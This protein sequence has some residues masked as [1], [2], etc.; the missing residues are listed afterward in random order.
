MPVKYFLAA[1]EVLK[2]FQ[3][4]FGSFFGS[5][6]AFFK[7]FFVSIWKFFGGSFVLQTCR[8]KRRFRPTCSVHTSCY[9]T[10][11]VNA[12]RF[13]A[14]AG[15]SERTAE[16]QR[17]QKKR[18]WN[19]RATRETL[20]AYT[21]TATPECTK[22]AHRRSLAILTADKSIAGNSATRVIFTRFHRRKHRGS[23][24]IFFT[25]EI[26]H[27]GASKIGNEKGT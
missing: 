2:L 14:R 17:Q 18:L 11:V 10:R 20:W 22:I 4:R 25:E 16:N 24:A 23:L 8:P 3:T 1:W 15:S 19:F 7:P 27:L 26:A 9:L 5:S 6:F 13:M 21:T 12:K